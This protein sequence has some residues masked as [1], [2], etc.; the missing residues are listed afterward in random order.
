MRE[1][2]GR[3]VSGEGSGVVGFEGLGVEAFVG[4]VGGALLLNKSRIAS[5]LLEMWNV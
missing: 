3:R 1:R 2:R 5:G 4:L